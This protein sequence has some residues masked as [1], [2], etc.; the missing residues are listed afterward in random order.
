MAGTPHLAEPDCLFRKYKTFGLITPCE[1]KGKKDLYNKKDVIF[2][3]NFIESSKNQ[4]KSLQ[5]IAGALRASRE[6][7]DV[8]IKHINDEKTK[9]P[10]LS[11]SK[12]IFISGGIEYNPKNEIFFLNL[13]T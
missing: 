11:H 1:K 12:Y 4:G 10:R 8:A 5:E 7:L 13:L 3:K 6:E 2:A 9:H